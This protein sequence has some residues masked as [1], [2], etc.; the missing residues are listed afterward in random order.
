MN[1]D[2]KFYKR[3]LK[4]VLQHHDII[5][6]HSKKNQEKFLLLKCLLELKGTKFTNIRFK[7]KNIHRNKLADVISGYSKTYHGTIEI[8]LLE[9]RTFKLTLVV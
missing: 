6:T 8:L 1:K 5:K 2:E 7:S 4:S 3:L 9:K